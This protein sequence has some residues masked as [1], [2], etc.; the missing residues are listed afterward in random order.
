MSVVLQVSDTQRTDEEWRY[1]MKSLALF[2]LQVQAS[3][4]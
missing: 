2:S 4:S 1:I 3:M